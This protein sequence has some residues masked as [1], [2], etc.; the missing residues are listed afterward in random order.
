MQNEFYSHS[1]EWKLNDLSWDLILVDVM[2]TVLV[3]LTCS[4]DKTKDLSVTDYV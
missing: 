1:S 3:T 4:M 2:F